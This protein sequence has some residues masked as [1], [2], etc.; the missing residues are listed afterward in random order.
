MSLAEQGFI[1]CS[2]ADQVRATA[3]RYYKGR[4]DIV[5][6]EIDRHKLAAPLKVEDGF[7]HIY[8]AL[9]RDAVVAVTPYETL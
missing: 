4:D 8:G 9:N 1:H 5:L 3:D 2:F 6:L 7:P